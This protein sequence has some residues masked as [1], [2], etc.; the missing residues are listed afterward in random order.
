MLDHI[1]RALSSHL[2][3]GGVWNSQGDD[4]VAKGHESRRE[5]P[6]WGRGLRQGCPPSQGWGSGGVTPGK[7]LKFETQSG[8]FWRQIGGSPDFHICEQKHCHN[9]RQW[10]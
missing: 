1:T 8:A 5:A 7:I 2:F 4:R 6:S 10:Y 9:A 3:Q